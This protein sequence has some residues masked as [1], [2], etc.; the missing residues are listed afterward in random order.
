[1]RLTAQDLIQ[2]AI[3]ADP[4]LI[5]SAGFVR[6]NPAT[7]E[8]TQVGVMARSL[9]EQEKVDGKPVLQSV[10]LTM[11]EMLPF[12]AQNYVQLETG[13]ILPKQPFPGSLSGQTLSGLPVPCRI[14]VSVPFQTG[15][16]HWEPQTYD[17]QESEIEL[18]FDVP[19]RY[20]ITVESVSHQSARFV[21]DTN[22]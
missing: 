8:I 4:G 5:E 14:K 10:V 22:G 3:D 15:L 19:D 12:L 9:I 13:T 17:V 2:N 1:M 20:E 21:V 18:S 11:D 6:Y 7:G 16:G